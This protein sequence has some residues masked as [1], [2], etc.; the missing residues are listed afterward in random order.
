M[1]KKH[2]ILPLALSCLAGLLA[3]R[4]DAMCARLRGPRHVEAEIVSCEAP[5]ARAAQRSEKYRMTPQSL[6]TILKSAPPSQVI[7]LRVLQYQQ[8]KEDAE[9]TAEEFAVLP[10][11][12]EEKPEAKEYFVDGAQSCDGY[13]AGTRA[14]FLER[15]NCCDTLP[16]RDLECLVG[17][18][19]LVPARDREEMLDFERR[20]DQG[21]VGEAV[22][23]PVPRLRGHTVSQSLG[24]MDGGHSPRLR[25]GRSRPR[26]LRSCRYLPAE[27]RVEAAMRT[28][29]RGSCS[30]RSTSCLPHRRK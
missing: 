7:S 3:P 29:F 5:Q 18:P 9:G 27:R 11:T 15:F 19:V 14:F 2:V 10:W 13:K 6:E 16:P 8:L 23:T 17:L 20:P 30:R 1:E 26:S 28:V 22:P 12:A 24:N 21:F 4:A 25:T